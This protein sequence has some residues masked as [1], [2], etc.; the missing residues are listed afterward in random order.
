MQQGIT[1]FTEHLTNVT[2]IVINL[3]DSSE[4]ERDY[5]QPEVEPSVAQQVSR[6]KSLTLAVNEIDQLAKRHGIEKIK[7]IGDNY[8]AAC[9]LFTTRMDHSKRS[10]DFAESVQSMLREVGKGVDHPFTAT[11]SVHSGDV[12]AGT[13]G[14]TKINF[15]LWG[16]TV[17]RIFQISAVLS[18]SD[19]YISQDVYE[20][21]QQLYPFELYTEASESFPALWTPKK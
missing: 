16:T 2:L 14:S 21:V 3:H 8:F 9:G 7:S 19:I 15:D 12:V 13:I 10:V 6:V 5:S 17:K 4:E 20:R 11:I 18:Q 1:D